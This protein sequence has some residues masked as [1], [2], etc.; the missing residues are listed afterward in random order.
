MKP[1]DSVDAA[2]TVI[3]L[4]ALLGLVC[5][6]ILEWGD[7]RESVGRMKSARAVRDETVKAGVA[8]Y[9]ADPVTGEVSFRWKTPHESECTCRPLS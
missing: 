8:E 3:G 9:H 5:C 4:I 6:L 1:F 2:V 7:N